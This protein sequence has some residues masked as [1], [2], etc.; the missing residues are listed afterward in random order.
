MHKRAIIFYH[1]RYKVNIKPYKNFVP[2][3]PTLNLINDSIKNKI[4]TSINIKIRY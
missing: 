4:L 1:I 3:N 2:N